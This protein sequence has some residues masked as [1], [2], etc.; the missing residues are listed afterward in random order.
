MAGTVGGNV[1]ASIELQ[2]GETVTWS[3]SASRHGEYVTTGGKLFLTDR[4]LLWAPNW[5]FDSLGV[6]TI[7]LPYAD[8]A[9]VA[10]DTE[11]FGGMLSTLVTGGSDNRLTIETVAG[12]KRTWS[13]STPGEAAE[14]IRAAMAEDGG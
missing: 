12:E 8:V 1:R 11:K 7:E 13:I 9:G 3:K 2:D 10:V 5:Y 6:E 4:R 14:R